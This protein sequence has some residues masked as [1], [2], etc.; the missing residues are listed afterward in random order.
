MS[1]RLEE[2]IN[3]WRSPILPEVEVLS[4]DNGQHLWR[5]FHETYTICTI[6]SDAWGEWIYRGKLTTGNPGELMLL[7]PGEIHDTKKMRPFSSFRVLFLNPVMVGKIC[8]EAG[9][10]DL[11][12]MRSCTTAS[13][14]LFSVFSRLHHLLEDKD[15]SELELQRLF[16]EGV[17]LLLHMETERGNI[18]RPPSAS[19]RALGRARDY[20]K[21][22]C[23][24]KVKLNDLARLAGLSPFHF[25]RAFTLEFGLPPHAYQ[26]RLRVARA[27]ELLARGIP[28]T[29]LDL[30]F[31]DQSHLIRHFKGVWGVTPGQYA[32]MLRRPFSGVSIA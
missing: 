18:L 27:R 31:S 9:I 24:S 21:E 1:E 14:K 17:G 32:E 28:S 26:I 13:P 2:K 16:A 22:H 25:L 8:R 6:R 7:E 29:Q 30:G 20:L 11:P 10:K 23:A 3:F 15:A 19:Q 5:V 4:V 12:H